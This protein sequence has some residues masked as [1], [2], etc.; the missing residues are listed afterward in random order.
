VEPFAGEP[1]AVKIGEKLLPFGSAFT[2]R[3]AEVDD[4]LLAIRTQS[5]S[6]E[7]RPAQ[8]AGAGLAGE[9]TPSSI[10]TL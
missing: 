2:R 6:N 8:R 1:A 5:Q 10:K 7:N 4:F 9:H 3:Q